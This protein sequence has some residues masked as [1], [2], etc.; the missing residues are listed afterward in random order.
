MF[1]KIII[2]AVC[3]VALP[4]LSTA[5]DIA[6]EVRGNAENNF[7]E[8]SLGLGHFEEHRN[9]SDDEDHENSGLA[10]G[11]SWEFHWKG[12]FTEA[13]ESANTTLNLGY[14]L[15]QSDRWSVDLI[16]ANFSGF[17]EDDND[18]IPGLSEEERNRRLSIRDTSSIEGGVR[19]THYL[20]NSIIQLRIESDYSNA[21]AGP[22]ASLV[23]GHAWQVRNWN[24]YAFSGASWSSRQRNQ[25]LWGITPEEETER[26]PRFQARS[27]VNYLMELGVTRPLSEHWLSRTT[28]TLNHLGR[29]ASSSPLSIQPLAGSIETSISYVF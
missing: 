27:S 11:I 17:S 22:V 14:K 26:F 25:F 18:I 15:W 7:F 9:I 5:S 16:A 29:G 20:D 21:K 8:I 1:K 10:L 4:S 19:L 12:F 2:F 24:I 3:S 6:R 13:I 28:A 23:F